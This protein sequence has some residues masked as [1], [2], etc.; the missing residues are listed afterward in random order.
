MSFSE[1][2]RDGRMT[3]RECLIY[4]F[5]I[6]SVSPRVLCEWLGAE[7]IQLTSM[8]LMWWGWNWHCT[9]KITGV[10]LSCYLK[11]SEASISGWISVGCSLLPGQLGM[12]VLSLSHHSV[13]VRF[14]WVK[15]SGAVLYYSETLLGYIQSM[16]SSL[17]CEDHIYKKLLCAQSIWAYRIKDF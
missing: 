4:P 10:L 8:P 13:V 11:I 17:S 7:Q 15:H 14:K 5:L 3:L 6:L 16:G 9:C 2:L 12:I 1:K